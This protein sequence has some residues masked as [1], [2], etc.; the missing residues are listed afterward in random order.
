MLLYAAGCAN[1]DLPAIRCVRNGSADAKS[2]LTALARSMTWYHWYAMGPPNNG[3][4]FLGLVGGTQQPRWIEIRYEVV[5]SGL[6]SHLPPPTC[7]A[8]VQDPLHP[9]KQASAP[10]SRRREQNLI[11]SGQPGIQTN[12]IDVHPSIPAQALAWC[13]ISYGPIA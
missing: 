2:K 6:S 7:H 13:C 11:C 10:K 1:G 3:F 9:S 4:W 5:S 8:L 12:R